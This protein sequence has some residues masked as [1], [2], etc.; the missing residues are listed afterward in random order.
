[1]TWFKTSLLNLRLIAAIAY[2][3]LDPRCWLWPY[4]L[5]F[6]H[7]LKSLFFFHRVYFTQTFLHQLSFSP[8]RSDSWQLVQSECLPSSVNNVGCSPF[9]FHESTIYSPVNSS[10][11]T[12]VTVQLPDHVSSGWEH[13]MT[14]HLIHIF[15]HIS[16]CLCC[17]LKQSLL[18]F[19]VYFQGYSVP[20]DSKGRDRRAAELGSGP[21]LHRRSLPGALQRPRLLYK[22]SGLHLWWGTP[23]WDTN[24]I[25]YSYFYIHIHS[26]FSFVLFRRKVLSRVSWWKGASDV[27]ETAF[28]IKDHGF[29]SQ[30]VF[31]PPNFI[32]SSH[33]NRWRLLTLQ[34]WPAQLHQGQLWVRQCVSGELAVDPGWRSGQRLWAAVTA[35]PWR[36]TLLQRL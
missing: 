33:V 36:L 17:Q 29:P 27:I 35:C 23:W 16:S 32:T 4:N 24:S 22:W 12:R 15:I 18:W 5:P 21:C 3:K 1:M 2:A 20:L 28:L 19:V 10:T 30:A 9:Q 8:F 6:K 31:F 25:L 13:N 26:L 11:W 14:S 7:Y 34:Q